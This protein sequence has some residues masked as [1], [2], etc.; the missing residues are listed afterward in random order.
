MRVLQLLLD[1]LSCHLLEFAAENTKCLSAANDFVHQRGFT[2]YGFPPSA[3]E[4][5]VIAFCARTL[6]PA[7]SSGGEMTAMPN[8][9]GE[10][11]IMPPPTPL[12]PGSPVRYSHFPESS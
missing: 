7:S 2:E 4:M 9:P 12:L 1:L 5:S 8:F 10:T 11:A 3:F 6:F